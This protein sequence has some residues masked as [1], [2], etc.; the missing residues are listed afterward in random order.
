MASQRRV[1][2]GLP[3]GVAVLALVVAATAPGASADP[4]FPVTATVEASTH[5]AKTGMNV[6]VPPGSFN[7][8][9]DLAN[10]AFNGTLSL[11]PAAVTIK[12]LGAVPLADATF[13]TSPGPISGHVD[14]ATLSVTTT[15][16]FHIR[17]TNVSPHGTDV[18]LAGSG[19]TTS[20]PI[21]VTMSGAFS[22]TAP[23]T[24]SGTYTIPTFEHCGALTIGLNQLIPGPG[25][26]L[27]ATFAPQGRRP[28]DDD[29]DQDAQPRALVPRRA[30]PGLAQRQ[31]QRA[32]V[33][34]APEPRRRGPAAARPR[35][36]ATALQ[37]RIRRAPRPALRRLSG[38]ADAVRRSRAPAADGRAAVSVVRAPP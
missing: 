14:F 31:R 20:K 38:A 9:V 22:L 7:G 27:S 13:A 10:G 21:T 33:R 23:S 35:P 2:A 11:P 28:P 17:I 26:T 1:L 36:D 34:R 16:T 25:N 24:F 37:L 8:A 3:L 12:L 5:I 15:S 18:N 32:P 29:H 6:T 19:C 4:T 30:D